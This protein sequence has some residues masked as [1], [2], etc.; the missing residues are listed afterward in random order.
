MGPG[1]GADPPPRESALL[2]GPLAVTAAVLLQRDHALSV[3]GATSHLPHRS[4][5]LSAAG[6]GEYLWVLARRVCVC[7]A[8]PRARAP[9]QRPRPARIPIR[10][11]ERDL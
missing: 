11:L 4:T 5:D 3:R 10:L 7:A 2:Q 1:H 8:A 9:D 6:N